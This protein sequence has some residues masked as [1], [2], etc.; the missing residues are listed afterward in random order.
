M[1]VDKVGAPFGLA[2]AFSTRPAAINGFQDTCP[3]RKVA[4]SKHRPN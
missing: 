2:V 4:A 3:I 1:L